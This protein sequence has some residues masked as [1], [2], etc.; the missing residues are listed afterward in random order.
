[1]L[2]LVHS[3]HPEGQ[4]HETK[5]YHTRAIPKRVHANGI[6]MNIFF[7]APISSV[8]MLLPLTPPPTS[9]QTVRRIET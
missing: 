6:A 1:M 2:P 7:S 3:T 4:A 8:R 5:R 9:M